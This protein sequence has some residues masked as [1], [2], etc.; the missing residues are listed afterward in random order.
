MHIYGNMTESIKSGR[1][2]VFFFY[3]VIN[4]KPETTSLSISSLLLTDYG[5]I[6]KVAYR[7]FTAHSSF[8]FIKLFL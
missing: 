7:N 1:F 8:P 4:L 2:I 3:V 5:S 6:V